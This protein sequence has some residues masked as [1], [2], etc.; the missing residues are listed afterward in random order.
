MMLR[1][2]GAEVLRNFTGKKIDS[3]NTE[4][5]YEWVDPQRKLFFDFGDFLMQKSKHEALEIYAKE[6]EMQLKVIDENKWETTV[7]ANE[8]I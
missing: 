4:I 8:L 7:F 3:K 1:F 5:V 2:G 6:K